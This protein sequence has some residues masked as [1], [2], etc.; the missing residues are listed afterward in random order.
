[1]KTQFYPGQTKQNF[2]NV[3]RVAILSFFFCV[4]MLHPKA[5]AQTGLQFKNVVL[6]SGTAGADN[7]V[8]RFPSVT[9]NI[10]ALVTIVGRSSSLVR[11]ESIDLTNTG[12]DKSFQPQVSFNGGTTPSGINDWWMEFSISFVNSSTGQPVNVNSFSTTALD[13]DGNG[14]KINEWV[15]FYGHTNYTVET[16]CMLQY[17]S[18][19]EMVN[20]INTAVGTKF[21]GPVRNFTD[22]DTSATSVMTTANFGNINGMR[23]RAGGRS[24]GVSG[25]SERMYSFW[26]KSFSYQ[27]PVSIRLPVVLASFT[28]KLENKKPV[29]SWVSSKEENLNVFVLERSA[30][31][32]NFKDAAM[33][34]P[35]EKTSADSKYS[36][37]DNAVST[38]AKGILYYRLR[39][40]DLDGKFKYSETRLLRISDQEKAVSIQTYPNPA[41]NELRITIPG[42]WQDKK[43]QY[44]VFSV[45]GQS[46]KKI[47][48]NNASQT[49]VLDISQLPAGSYIVR[50]SVDNETAT[51]QFVKSK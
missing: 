35:N 17:G 10:D 15:S 30:D 47:S 20:G 49:E 34:F 43:I 27:D 39:M 41:I 22:I 29:I 51:Q 1:M 36:Y 32:Q 19:W 28:A 3:C 42:N 14:D 7:A 11:L 2:V 50:V 18:V 45:T 46:M 26:F 37:T 33:I 48:R 21:N 8:Y 9:T 13:I 25:A 4:G 6:K 12:F 23:M 40:V 44:D 16:D 31:G 24:T 5:K 38:S